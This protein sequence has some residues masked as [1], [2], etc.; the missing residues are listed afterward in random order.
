MAC[1]PSAGFF[2]CR[3]RPSLSEV[4]LRWARTDWKAQRSELS[5]RLWCRRRIKEAQHRIDTRRPGRF[6]VIRALDSV[7]FKIV[8]QVPTALD[9]GGA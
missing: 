6:T 3:L 7:I 8:V 2:R 5:R 9:Q 1:A 4:R